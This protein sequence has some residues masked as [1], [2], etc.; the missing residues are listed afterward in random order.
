MD[1]DTVRQIDYFR[2]FKG[3]DSTWIS[4]DEG[5]EVEQ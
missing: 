1:T 4:Y 5:V 2:N 3:V